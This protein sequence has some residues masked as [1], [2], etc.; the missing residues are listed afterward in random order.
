MSIVGSAIRPM[1]MTEADTNPVMADSIE[2]TIRVA[3]S[4]PPG[5]LRNRRPRARRVHVVHARRCDAQ[6]LAAERIAGDEDGIGQQAPAHHERHL[7]IDGVD[8][9]SKAQGCGERHRVAR[10]SS[11][12]RFNDTAHP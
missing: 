8:A 7:A 11:A 3:T 10:H 4:K 9:A 12:A 6:Q 5:C 2:P 1:A